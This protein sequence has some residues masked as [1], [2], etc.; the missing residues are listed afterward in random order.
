MTWLKWP[1]LWNSDL[2]CCI[3]CVYITCKKK[4]FHLFFVLFTHFCIFLALREVKKFSSN[5]FYLSFRAILHVIFSAWYFIFGSYQLKRCFICC[6]C[7]FLLIWSIW[8][9]SIII[10][11][12]QF[13]YHFDNDIRI[14]IHLKFKLSQKQK[15]WMINKTGNL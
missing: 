2:F 7:I 1:W 11:M 15:I 5:A 9:I 6:F 8:L 14:R 10:F 13:Y 12:R 3:L 4:V